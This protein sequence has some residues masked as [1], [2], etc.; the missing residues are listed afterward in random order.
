MTESTKI[1][2]VKNMTDETDTDVISAFLELA[3]DAIYHYADPYKQTDK[4]ELIEQY[5]GVQTRAAAYFLNKRGAEGESGH[6]ENGIS[7][8]YESA[9]LP[10]TLLREITPIC[11]V[12]S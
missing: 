5:G 10:E 12:V 8:S 2:I 4:N 7:R 6:S 9:D 1:A 11:G 3:G